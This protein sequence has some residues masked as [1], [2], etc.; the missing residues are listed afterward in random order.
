MPASLGR[1][2][3]GGWPG[4]RPGRPSRL[5][6][7]CEP[8]QGE[9]V[10]GDQVQVNR[11]VIAPDFG[12]RVAVSARFREFASA[13]AD[14]VFIR[15][16][17]RNPGTVHGR[18]HDSALLSRCRALAMMPNRWPS[19]HFTWTVSRESMMSITPAIPALTR[20]ASG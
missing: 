18:G 10:T 17:P 13:P 7:P 15:L 3:D 12:A 19:S 4:W 14:R 8:V 16:H 20:N 6:R 9:L 2:G 11:V 5:T 1:G